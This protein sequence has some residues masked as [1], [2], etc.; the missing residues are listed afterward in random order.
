[1]RASAPVFIFCALE[2][3]SRGTDG[4]GSRFFVLRSRTHFR[5]V[6]MASGLVLMFYAP[7]LVF[8]GSVSI[9][10]RFHV[11]HS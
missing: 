9:G 6:T 8:G 7:G 1:M 4:V 11:L 10:S 3:V 5:Q 2:H